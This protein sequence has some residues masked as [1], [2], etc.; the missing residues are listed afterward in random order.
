MLLPLAVRRAACRA[1]RTFS[2]PVSPNSWTMARP[3]RIRAPVNYSLAHPFADAV[4]VSNV[5]P[6]NCASKNLHCRWGVFHILPAAWRNCCVL[7]GGHPL[8]SAFQHPLS[9]SILPCVDL[10]IDVLV[11][12]GGLCVLMPLG[13]SVLAFAW[14]GWVGRWLLGGLMTWAMAFDGLSLGLNGVG[15][16]SWCGRGWGS[17]DGVVR[18]A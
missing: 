16:V 5:H 7:P 18:C 9:C 17:W 11:A 10:D 8:S 12:L 14:V 3:F 4:A 15:G 6:F 13:P 1:S 2:C